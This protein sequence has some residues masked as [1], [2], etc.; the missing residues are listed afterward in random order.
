MNHMNILLTNDDGIFGE[1]LRTLASALKRKGHHVTVVAPHENNS[2]VSH[3]I[4][5]QPGLKISREDFDG[6]EAYSVTGTPTDCVLLALK[7]LGIRPD[8][9]ISGVN[10]GL[11]LGVDTLYSGTVAG[12]MEGAVCGIPSIALSQRLHRA[13]T[14]EEITAAFRR[15]CG[16]TIEKLQDWAK[17]A[18]EA[19]VVNINFPDCSPKGFSFCAAAKSWYQTTYYTEEG[20]GLGI[21]SSAPQFEGE[22][23]ILYLREGYVTIT[24][25]RVD[26]TNDELLA[27]WRKRYA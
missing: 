7:H 17:L 8:L 16:I 22:G 3:K 12:A 24:P 13:Y 9:L 2:A 11:N 1:G 14:P 20:V 5:M 18:Q 10:A 21:V 15:A 6:I 4:T 23:D 26:F 19:R 27:E 25:L